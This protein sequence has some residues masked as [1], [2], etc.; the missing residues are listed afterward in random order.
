MVSNLTGRVASAGDIKRAR[1]EAEKEVTSDQF[2]FINPKDTY[3][4]KRFAGA[5]DAHNDLVMYADQVIAKPTDSEAVTNY[6]RHF[7]GDEMAMNKKYGFNTTSMTLDAR[8]AKEISRDKVTDYTLNNLDEMLDILKKDDAGK[9]PAEGRLV[10]LVMSLPH[11]T[12]RYGEDPEH[13]ARVALIEKVQTL[14]Q[15][16]QEED[17]NKRAQMMAREVQKDIKNSKMNDHAKEMLQRFPQ[18]NVEEHFQRIVNRE[19]G[20]LYAVMNYE[21]AYDIFRKDFQYIEYALHEEFI[22]PDK[23]KDIRRNVLSQVANAIAGQV[24]EIEDKKN[25]AD[26]E[27]MDEKKR[28]KNQRKRQR[29]AQRMGF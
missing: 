4:R 18:R 2:N 24:F 11:I 3:D 10:K 28:L 23:V 13:D 17:S 12:S 21:T 26:E 7:Y 6:G 8:R 19:I 20:V 16:M 9:K 15:I 1:A 22:A 25:D 29:K 27:R 14:Q 5:F